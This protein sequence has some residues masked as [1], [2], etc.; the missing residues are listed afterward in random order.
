MNILVLGGS[1]FIGRNLIEALYKESHKIYNFD[2]VP[3]PD[4]QMCE[5]IVGGF[6]EIEIIEKIMKDIDVVYHLISTTTPK[7]SIEDPEYCIKT[8]VLGT[9]RLLEIC[10]K[11]EIKHLI[12]TSSGG[13]VYGKIHEMPIRETHAT[14]PVCT[15]GI[16]KLTVEKLLYMY[17]ELYGL[18]YTVMRLANPYGPHQRVDAAQGAVMVFLN[19]CIHE[20]KVT[21]WGDGTII[22]DYIYIEDAVGALM[23]PLDNMLFSGVY[24]V[25]TGVGYSL[26]ELLNTI[27]M[28]VQ[29]PINI[30][31]VEGR[32]IDVK[33]N[34][35]CIEKAN[36]DLNWKP[37]VVLSDG[38]LKTYQWLTA[39]KEEN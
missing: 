36:N 23:A 19:K 35:L 10:K 29:K 15:Y 34:V 5:S 24:N 12:Y 8:N 30:E 22:R 31:Y 25:G 1:G 3:Y 32:N 17:G 11:Y 13:T 28:V 14:E 37:K 26:N 4:F 20:Q 16:S 33:E 21:V 38:I 18:N 6:E 9:L 7:T 2:I 27:S 39:C